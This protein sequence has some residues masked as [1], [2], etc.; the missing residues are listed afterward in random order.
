M[1]LR[2][3]FGYGLLLGKHSPGLIGTSCDMASHDCHGLILWHFPGRHDD[4][5]LYGH[6]CLKPTFPTSGI[7]S[8]LSAVLSGY[9]DDMGWMQKQKRG[10]IEYT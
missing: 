1:A 6:I 7:Y 8:I 5:G 3:S 9:K 10:E 4:A 2:N